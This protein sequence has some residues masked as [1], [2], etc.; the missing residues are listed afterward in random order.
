MDVLPYVAHLDSEGVLQ[1][2]GSLPLSYFDPQRFNNCQIREVSSNTADAQ[3]TDSV[4]VGDNSTAA[5]TNSAVAGSNSFVRTGAVVGS[6]NLTQ[7]NGMEAVV[8]SSNGPLN[9]TT[10]MI[11][12][13]YNYTINTWSNSAIIGYFNSNFFGTTSGGIASFIGTQHATQST[14]TGQHAIVGF[15]NQGAHGRTCAIGKDAHMVFGDRSTV[16][17]QNINCT[18]NTSGAFHTVVGQDITNNNTNDDI[19]IGKN[20]NASIPTGEER[21][22]IGINLTLDTG[23]VSSDGC[24]L[25]IGQNNTAALRM[26]AS[27]CYIPRKSFRC[28]KSTYTDAVTVTLTSLQSNELVI[29][30]TASSLVLPSASELASL[31]PKVSTFFFRFYVINDSAGTLTI[32]PGTGGTST[33]ATCELATGVGGWFTIRQTSA[34]AYTLNKIK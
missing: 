23:F 5:G 19:V 22:I 25:V 34:S 9:A 3:G 32:T 10:N 12:G 20:I 2:C 26:A 18:G 21:C 33:G 28:I 16:I 4:V 24:S 27:T 31:H 11:C 14:S 29:V 6:Y 13:A 8:G 15:S 1:P 17:G 7:P 30:T